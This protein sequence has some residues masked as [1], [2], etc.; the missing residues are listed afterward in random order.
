MVDRQ[1][2]NQSFTDVSL[3]IRL[4]SSLLDEMLDFAYDRAHEYA[5]HDS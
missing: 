1:Y 3:K 4:F 5:I 2:S